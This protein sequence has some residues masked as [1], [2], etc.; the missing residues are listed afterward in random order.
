M[1]I[2]GAMK[3]MWETLYE[4]LTVWG[5]IFFFPSML[6]IFPAML[7]FSVVEIVLI[8]VIWIIAVCHAEGF[9]LRK[10]KSYVWYL[11]H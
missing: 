11:M 5:K 4:C 9:H 6:L 10:W 3:R 8:D 1:Y 2:L 7:A